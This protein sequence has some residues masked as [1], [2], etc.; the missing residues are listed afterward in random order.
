MGGEIGDVGLNWEG[1]LG[2]WIKLGGNFFFENGEIGAFGRIRDVGINWEGNWG[3]RKILEGNWDVGI[4][5][6]GKLGVL[7]VDRFEN[8]K[9]DI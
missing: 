8:R 4:N 1:K 7:G 9:G 3:V 6:G 5:W 2:C